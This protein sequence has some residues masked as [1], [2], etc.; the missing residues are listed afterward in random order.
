LLCQ[1]PINDNFQQNLI[2]SYWAYIASVLEQ[3][4]KTAQEN[5]DKTRDG[6]EKLDF[7]QFPESDILS[8][9]LK[10]NNEEALKYAK[11]VLENQNLLALS[12]I[13]SINKNE[14]SQLTEIKIDLLMFDNVLVD[15]NARI[16][17]LEEN[18]QNKI[19]ALFLKEKTYLAHKEKLNI[20]YSEIESLH[21]NMIW[22]HKANLFNKQWYKTQSTNTEKRLSSEF[23][24]ANYISSFNQE[25]DEL[26]GKF[27]IMIDAKSSDAQSN[28]QL[29]LKG[30]DPSAILSEGEQKVI[31]LAD[32]IAETN[33]TIINKGIV[34]DDPVTSL[35]EER[36]S[37]IAKRLVN[38][39][40]QKQVIIFTHDL[41]FVSSLINFASD[42]NV[43]NE[44][45]W[46]ENRN[47]V[48]GQVWLRNSPTYEK[49][50]RN[51]EPVKE[52]YNV[53]K[54]DDCPPA[55]REYQVRNGFTALRTCYEVLVINDLFKNVVQRYNE[56]VSVDSLSSVYFDEELINELLDSFAHCC[57]Y[58]EG[59]THSDKY[60]YL[61]PEPQNLNDEIQRYET[62]R[63]KIRKNKKSP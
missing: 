61:K 21:K 1:Q 39:S 58:M 18:E 62:I 7:N 29:F 25:C 24:N 9:W 19:L 33:I 52:F 44:C 54:K 51:S 38:I 2:Q 46:I 26:N 3:E 50:Y 16:K 48:P 14:I 34:L 31:A 13:N 15:L 42:N 43:P 59:H 55:E 11:E 4:A 30:K 32:F 10:E 63:T 60:A 22:V 49:V 41:V 36:K 56:R 27:G 47:G 17:A 45:H 40:T 5:L 12:I 53:A 37:T 23:F 35:D 8:A 28:R 6:Y 20:R 57:R